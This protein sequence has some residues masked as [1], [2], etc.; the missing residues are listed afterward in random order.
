ML[1]ILVFFFPTDLGNG[2]ESRKD[3]DLSSDL[4]GEADEDWLRIHKMHCRYAIRLSHFYVHRIF[5][6]IAHL[7]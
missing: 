6:K 4:K 7:R 5:D 1:L 3:E 2:K